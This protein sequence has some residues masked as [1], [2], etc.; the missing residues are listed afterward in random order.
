[1]QLFVSEPGS[2]VAIENGRYCVRKSEEKH[3]FPTHEVASIYIHKGVSIS[4]E[5]IML[6][7][8]NETDLLIIGQHGKPAG[9]LWGE[10][11]GSIST[12]RKNQL[13]F[14]KLDFEKASWVAD[15]LHYKIDQQIHLLDLCDCIYPAAGMPLN[16]AI[17][18]LE[19]VKAKIQISNI[20]ECDDWTDKW[21]GYEGVASK[22]YFAQLSALLPE[23]YRFPKRTRPATDRFNALLNYC[24]G[25]LY[26]KVEG[27]LL[28]AGLDPYIGIF[29]RDEYNRP[30][31]VYDVIERF[32][33]WADY[34]V[35]HLCMQQV[36]HLDFFKMADEGYLN[37]DEDAKRIL[38]RAFFDYLEEIVEL[39][40][41]ERS[42]L[43]HIDLYCQQLATFF[44][45][46][47][48]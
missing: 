22:I 48:L 14:S 7:L 38:V 47:T 9:R 29:H 10:K 25:I 46:I 12:I 26:S 17:A 44:K 3:Y 15:L 30:S 40:N 23:E 31:L 2:M 4:H 37:I 13:A 27:A 33:V 6:A 11:P 42:R 32:R 1:M 35:L 39:D 41:L 24:Y 28:K 16:K 43:V 20:S 36:M 21:R 8:E 5:A 18:D 19:K 45:N 34:T